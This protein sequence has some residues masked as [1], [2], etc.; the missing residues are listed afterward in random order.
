MTTI[1]DLLQAATIARQ[2]GRAADE[3]CLLDR[4]VV[5][6]PDDANVQNLLGLRA[7]ADGDLDCAVVNFTRAIDL[8]PAEPSLLLNLATAQ[9][10]LGDTGAEKQSLQRALALDQLQFM[11]QLRIA[12]LLEREGALSAAARHWSAVVQLAAGIPSPPP[13]V[14]EAA[15]RGQRFLAE[16]NA[17]FAVALDQEIGADISGDPKSKRFR[18]CVDAMLGRRKIYRNE[19]AGIHYPFLPAEEFFDRSLFPWLADIE[20]KTAAIRRE[21]LSLLANGSEALRPYVRLEP[22]TPVNKWTTLDHS[23]EW[24]ACF[25]WE[26]GTRN[27]VVCDLCPET[28]A[29]LAALPQNNIPGK[30]PSAFFSILRAG[31][32]IPPHTGVT[33]TRAIIHLPLVVPRDCGFRVGG[34]TRSWIEGEAFAFDDTIE[35]EAWNDSDEQRIVLIFD[36]WN[37]HLSQAEQRLLTNLFQVADRE[38][39]SP[40]AG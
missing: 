6:D 14:L 19:C 13:L 17:A 31:A 30:A 29:A 38:I 28:V 18:V 40:K 22:G 2:Q 27:D 4:A 23:L 39:V 20:S 9:R 35:H 15:A 16:H 24:G 33:N 11:G 7:L 26:Y 25:L 8:D 1:A 21:A 12:E 34:E 3:R 37:P 32:R 36:V 5:L 10:R